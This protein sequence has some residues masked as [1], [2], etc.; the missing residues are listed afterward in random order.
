MR[1]GKGALRG[2]VEDYLTERPGE[3]FSPSRI[4]KALQRSSG[5]VANALEKLVTDGY[6]TQTQDK[7][8]R[9]VAKATPDSAIS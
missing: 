8:K 9:F 6:A 4:G 1:L 3:Q 2:M 7:P 5:A